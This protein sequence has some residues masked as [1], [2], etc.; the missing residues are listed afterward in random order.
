MVRMKDDFCRWTML[1]EM[2][3][4]PIRI[5]LK[6]DAKPFTVN[7]PWLIPLI[8]QDTVKQELDAV[9]SQGIIV[10]AITVPIGATAS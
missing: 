1:E 8:W 3:G 6:D 4:P 7:I 9:V 2:C 10:L 5:C